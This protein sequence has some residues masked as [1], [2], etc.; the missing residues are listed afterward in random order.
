MVALEESRQRGL[1]HTLRSIETARHADILA[2]DE[3]YLLATEQLLGHNAGQ[4]AYE[5]SFAIDHNL[6]RC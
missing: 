6:S 2:S 1:K 3:D 5:M 4:A